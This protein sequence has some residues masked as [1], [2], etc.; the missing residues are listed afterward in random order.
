MWHH[1]FI[2]FPGEGNAFFN[3]KDSFSCVPHINNFKKRA[4]KGMN[5]FMQEE[6]MDTCQM[7]SQ[8]A[9]N[10]PFILALSCK[11]LTDDNKLL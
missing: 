9:R 4:S 2:K 10:R 11:S 3:E 5:N 1:I 7:F 8:V 6:R